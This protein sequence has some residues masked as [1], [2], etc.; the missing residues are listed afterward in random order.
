MVL[1][2]RGLCKKTN[3]VGS[4][5]EFLPKMVIKNQFRKKTR[6]RR[7]LAKEKD[8]DKWNK[9]NQEITL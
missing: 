8:R 6:L 4:I 9:I 7:K 5:K 2:F 3:N 1:L